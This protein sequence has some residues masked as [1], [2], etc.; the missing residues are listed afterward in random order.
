[1]SQKNV[2]LK[3]NAPFMSCITINGM[4]IDNTKDLDIVMLMYNL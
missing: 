1:M 4:L 3:N 2:V